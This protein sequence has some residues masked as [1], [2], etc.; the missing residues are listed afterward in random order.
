MIYITILALLEGPNILRILTLNLAELSIY[1][2]ISALSS[3]SRS[4][5]YFFKKGLTYFYIYLYK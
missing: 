3:L 5:I 4:S 2:L 1:S